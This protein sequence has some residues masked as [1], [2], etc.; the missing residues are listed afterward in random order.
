MPKPT[1]DATITFLD[2]EITALRDSIT[3]VER[4]RDALRDIVLGAVSV[5]TS[6]LQKQHIGGAIAHLEGWLVIQR[7]RLIDREEQA[8]KMG[9]QVGAALGQ[10]VARDTLKQA[11]ASSCSSTTT[12]S[13]SPS[14]PSPQ[15]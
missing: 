10:Q 13:T 11:Q 6:Q 4:Q 15:D 7:F 14:S 2:A 9:I 5:N 8:R 3:Q 12:S 1:V